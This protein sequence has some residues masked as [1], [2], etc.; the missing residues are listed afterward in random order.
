M[1]PNANTGTLLDNTQ[2]AKGP[3]NVTLAY[4]QNCQDGTDLL[5]IRK[6]IW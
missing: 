4:L 6:H 5:A 2:V 3:S 1:K